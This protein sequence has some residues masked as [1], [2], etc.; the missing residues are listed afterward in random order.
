MKKKR[1]VR[2]VKVVDPQF[3]DGGVIIDKPKYFTLSN[4]EVWAVSRKGIVKV[5]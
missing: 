4:G 2:R 1:K 5:C 3:V